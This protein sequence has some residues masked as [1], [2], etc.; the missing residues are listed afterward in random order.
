MESQGRFCMSIE[1]PN[2]KEAA[3]RRR[4]E[5]AIEILTVLGFGTHPTPGKR[6]GMTR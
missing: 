1:R 6:F 5:E 3:R 4:L 2:R